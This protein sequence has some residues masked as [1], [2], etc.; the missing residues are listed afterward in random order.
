MDPRTAELVAALPEE[1]Q[2]PIS[3]DREL[4]E[5][6]Q[7]LAHKP[8]PTGRVLRMWSL[9]TL[10][11]KI[12]AAYTVWWLRSGFQDAEAKQRG[13]DETHVATAVQVLG[14][15]SYLRGA[16]MK[17]GQVIAHWPEVTPASFAGVP[18]G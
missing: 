8:V 18:I 11:A 3:R 9:G 12:A 4:Q 10:Q 7:T 6:L 16:V 2:E 17:L 5:L 13:L 15:M 14:R 1:L